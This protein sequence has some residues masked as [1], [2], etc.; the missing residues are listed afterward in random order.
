[1][2]LFS[3]NKERISWEE[4]QAQKRQKTFDECESYIEEINAICEENGVVFGGIKPF[5]HQRSFCIIW[6]QYHV[7][8]DG[9]K[10]DNVIPWIGDS[11]R[12]LYL[13]SVWKYEYGEHTQRVKR[14]FFKCIPYD[15]I[16]FFA[17]EGDVVRDYQM[18][19]GKGVSVGGA[20]AGAMVA[21]SAGMVIGATKDRNKST[22]SSTTKDNRKCY[23]Y[24]IEND[25][26]K[27]LIL[28][29]TGGYQGKPVEFYNYMLEHIPGKSQDM[30]VRTQLTPQKEDKADEILKYKKLLDAGAITEEEFMTL[31]KRLLDL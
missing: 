6:K 29:E 4:M 16:L 27:C 11:D 31:K 19:N 26:E 1:M 5:V 3:R 25:I 18:E 22:I 15:K 14:K 23:I 17:M 24:Y 30:F 12:N 21:G 2:G 9:Q 20:I 8:I 28:Q 10:E 13:V 7:K